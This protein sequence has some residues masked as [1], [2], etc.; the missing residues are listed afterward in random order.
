MPRL[1]STLSSK[2]LAPQIAEF[3]TKWLSLIPKRDFYP[4]ALYNEML[5]NHP[6]VAIAAE[7]RV[8]Y[9]LSLMR[10]YTHS[11]K[12]I[13]DEIRANFALMPG[14]W[15]SYQLKMLQFL[16]F[17]FSFAE[18]A[19]TV[20]KG[21]ATIA[22]L[23]PLHQQWCYFE[24]TQAGIQNVIYTTAVDSPISIPY[25]NGI[26]L[27][28]QDYLI[29]GYDPYGIALLH[30][31]VQYWE[32]HRL[33][34]AAMAIA[35]QRQA[36]PI[37]V[38]KTNINDDIELLDANGSPLLDAH[39]NP[40]KRKRG[41]DMQASLEQLENTSVMVIDLV[42]EVEAIAQQTDGAFF[43]SILYYLDSMILGCFLISPVIAGTS[44]SGLGDSSLIDGHLRTLATVSRTQ[45]R[46]FGDTLVQQLV[47]PVLDF[48]YRK[49]DDYGSFPV[50]DEESKN[51]VDLLNAINNGVR[52]GTFSNQDL[53]VVSKAKDLAGIAQ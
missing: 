35:G 34:M 16:I 10:D 42:D 18:R 51:T 48:N 17:G 44:E 11:D 53:A 30:R 9:S 52:Y 31:A 50:P 32:L 33:I 12:A 8:L 24:G 26:H 37:L 45:M 7:L 28:N 3:V 19:F 39:G 5:R 6:K 25:Q 21:K 46:M 41:D 22:A 27:I 38:G 36:T 23:Q 2:I 49:I 20:R 13:Q 47:R 15:A 14:S 40:L 4:I 1:P 29:P 43:R